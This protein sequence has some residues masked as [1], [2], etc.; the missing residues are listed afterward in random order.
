M[1][2]HSLMKEVLFPKDPLNRYDVYTLKYYVFYSNSVRIYYRFFQSQDPYYIIESNYLPDY[3]IKIN[4][5]SAS[6]QNIECPISN[7]EW[8][9]FLIEVKLIDNNYSLSFY[10]NN[11]TTK[12]I[13]I[14]STTQNMN[15]E[16]ILYSHFDPAYN[17]IAWYGGFYKH[18]RV[19]NGFAVNIQA[20]SQYKY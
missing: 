1:P 20:V 4:S 10:F 17:N 13:L 16:H 12:P 18:L 19:W 2:D 5:G 15:L 14:G 7:Y 6:Y 9:K 8:N 11:V 3:K